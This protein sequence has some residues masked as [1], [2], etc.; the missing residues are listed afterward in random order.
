MSILAALIFFLM[1][2]MPEINADSV[3]LE[4]AKRYI[5]D[6]DLKKEGEQFRKVLSVRD[7]DTSEGLSLTMDVLPTTCAVSSGMSI[8]EVYS[9]ACPTTTEQYEEIECQLKLDSSNNGQITLLSH[10]ATSHTVSL[11]PAYVAQLEIIGGG[12]LCFSH[13]GTFA[14][15]SML[16]CGLDGGV[17]ATVLLQAIV[18]SFLPVFCGREFLCIVYLHLKK[19]INK[20]SAQ[21]PSTSQQKPQTSKDTATVP[22]FSIPTSQP[23]SKYSQL[24][25]VIEELG[26]DIR[27]TYSGNKMSAERLK[28]SIIHA[29]IL[30]RECIVETEKAANKS[31]M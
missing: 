27:P 30:V 16:W 8:E 13:L 11:V 28:R 31:A 29:R 1:A 7:V 22:Q 20:M 10:L 14:V 23:Q 24:L 15:G 6:S 12:L 3:E 4:E 21:G 18:D 25:A 9:D 2:V 19:D 5:Y 26:K 17:S